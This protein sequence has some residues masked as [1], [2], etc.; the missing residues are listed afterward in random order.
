MIT[1]GLDGHKQKGVEDVIFYSKNYI[2]FS[3]EPVYVY[4]KLKEHGMTKNR[5]LEHCFMLL[6]F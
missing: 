2:I 6:Y 3:N 5:F 4:P 1:A